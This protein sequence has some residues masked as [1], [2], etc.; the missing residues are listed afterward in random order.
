[1]KKS[2]WKWLTPLTFVLFVASFFL[3]IKDVPLVIAITLSVVAHELAHMVALKILDY[4][5]NLAFL[6]FLGAA[7]IPSDTKGYLNSPDSHKAI[8]AL[9]GPAINAILLIVSTLLLKNPEI[10]DLAADFV[11][12]NFILIVVNLAPIG[13]FDGSKI[14]SAILK[15]ISSWPAKILLMIYFVVISISSLMF[16]FC[17]DALGTTWTIIAIIVVSLLGV[18][19]KLIPSQIKTEAMKTKLTVGVLLGYSAISTLNF[20]YLHSLLFR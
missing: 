17:N 11:N 9:A 8:T 2:F 20:L 12:I 19:A 14:A 6:P 10:Y 15:G 1:M 13:P 4:Q 16:I 7:T 5:A 18:A 3:L